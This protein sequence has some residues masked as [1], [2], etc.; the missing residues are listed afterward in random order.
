MKQT[1]MES[2]IEATM[3]TMIGFVVSLA[4]GYYV[5]PAFGFAVTFFDNVLIT[6]IFTVSSIL[7]SYIVRRW[8]N[9]R[10]HRLAQRLARAAT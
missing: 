5:F 3:S 9:A 7:R 10:L 2:L 1:K 4:L 6:L 8:F